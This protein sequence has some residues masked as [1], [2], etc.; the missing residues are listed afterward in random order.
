MVF[1]GNC[2]AQSSCSLLD[3]SK[4]AQFITYEGYGDFQGIKLRLTNNTT[5]SI[6]VQRGDSPPMLFVKLSNGKTQLQFPAKAK[7][8]TIIGLHYYVQNR[9]R[10][11]IPEP[12]LSWGDSVHTY[13]I[14]AGQS[15][16]F[17]VSQ[18][19]F[20]KR[21]DI[22]VSFKY[23]WESNESIGLTIG[24]VNHYVYFLVEDLPEEAVKI[25]KRCC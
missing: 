11:R 8:G 24:G 9:E 10:R 25:V 16:I 22:V 17:S 18:L 2:F 15:V 20:K 21:L 5:C 19:H 12:G 4:K 7:D 6:I 14:P 13:E 1:A 23:E 3:K